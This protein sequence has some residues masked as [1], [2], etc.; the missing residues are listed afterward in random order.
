MF[1][2]DLVNP[3]QNYIEL[4]KG[5]AKKTTEAYIEDARSFVVWSEQAL[6]RSPE[7]GNITAID[8]REY[9]SYLRTIRR[10]TPATVNRRMAGLKEFVRWMCENGHMQR[11]PVFPR[12]IR[13]QKLKPQSLSRNEQNRLLRELERGSARNGALVRLM[14]SCGLR[15]G[16]VIRLK[17]GDVEISERRGR[18]IVRNGK[19]KKHREVPIPYQARKAM[20]DWLVERQAFSPDG[21][22]LFPNRSKFHISMRA[23]EQVVTDLGRIAGFYLRTHILRH[24]CATNMLRSGADL[25]TVART[26]GHESLNTTAIYTQPGE[27]EMRQ[28]MERAEI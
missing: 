10:L 7:P 25:V 14:L 26:L 19:G 27:N 6:G 23:A 15:V 5:L 12:K 22:W 9:Q 3:F 16:E 13:H 2:I 4:E 20:Q 17:L 18:V 8:L 11:H 24:T 28:A 21:E 1:I